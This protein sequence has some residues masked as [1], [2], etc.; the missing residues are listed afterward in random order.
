MDSNLTINSGK[1]TMTGPQDDPTE[2]KAEL[3]VGPL[4]CE[5]VATAKDGLVRALF[6]AVLESFIAN[7]GKNYLE[8][9]AIQSGGEEFRILV[10]NGG[11]ETPAQQ[12]TR[13]RAELEAAKRERVQ[14]ET[15]IVN[16]HFKAF[17]PP[18]NYEYT[19][20]A[21]A[22]D[23]LVADI[24]A[25]QHERDGLAAA[26]QGLREALEAVKERC[27]SAGEGAAHG[28]YEDI[29]E[30]VPEDMRWCV[31][32]IDAALTAPAPEALERLK[33]VA[34]QEESRRWVDMIRALDP[35]NLCDFIDELGAEEYLAEW[36]KAVKE[37][38]KVA[39]LEEFATTEPILE[40][41]PP[42]SV[43]PYFADK[44]AAVACLRSAVRATLANALKK[45]AELRG[46]R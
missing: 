8:Y 3:E 17:G 41:D 44:D 1:I 30:H 36:L 4:G 37:D 40:G 25:T 14:L 7:G 18:R 33:W 34:T 9:T 43:V 23:L 13:L 20:P 29:R 15:L 27:N 5:V 16:A 2:F 26:N 31:E 42:E 10:Q 32:Q 38:A 19:D 12:N 6:E 22:L 11:A 28:A 39:A 46:Q 35:E 45:A 21:S 24:A